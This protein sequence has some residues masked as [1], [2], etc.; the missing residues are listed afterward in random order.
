MFDFVF[1]LFGGKSEAEKLQ[2]LAEVV[3]SLEVP[4]EDE[5]QT[6][7]EIVNGL[8]KIQENNQCFK[9]TGEI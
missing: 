5:E 4:S 3:A 9:K 2:E 1:K 8:Q 6:E 7:K